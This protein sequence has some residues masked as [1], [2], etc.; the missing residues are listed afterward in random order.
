MESFR[1][2]RISI[3]SFLPC[4][5]LRLGRGMWVWSKWW[6]SGLCGLANDCHSALM[7]LCLPL[8]RRLQVYCSSS[9]GHL[10]RCDLYAKT[11]F[12]SPNQPHIPTKWDLSHKIR[13]ESTGRKEMLDRTEQIR[14]EGKL[15]PFA[16]GIRQEG[17]RGLRIKWRLKPPPRVTCWILSL[18]HNLCS[19]ISWSWHDVSGKRKVRWNSHYEARHWEEVYLAKFWELQRWEASQ[20]RK[21]RC[22]CLGIY[23]VKACKG[24]SVSSRVLCTHQDL[25][26]GWQLFIELLPC[27]M[28]AKYFR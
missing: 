26:M 5:L 15:F 7:S 20:K 19:K 12:F 25:K 6:T 9:L 3:E 22:S 4:L 10:P 21:G 18:A 11:H 14:G 23:Q 2:C 28:C 27:T 16:Q 8:S 17:G 24:E 13:G 1:E